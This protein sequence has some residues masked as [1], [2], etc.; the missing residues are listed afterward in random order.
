M[1]KLK[2]FSK[3]H[4]E[5]F[6]KIGIET[7]YLFGSQVQGKTHQL[8][9]FDF[10]VIFKKPE[11]YRDNTMEPYLKLYDILTDVLPKNYLKRRLKLKEH[12]LDIVFLQFAP[13]S[14]QFNAIK[15]SKVLYEKNQEKRLN[16]KENILK[17][18]CDFKYFY[19]LSYNYLLKRL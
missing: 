1:I 5:Q 3:K 17:K 8:S 6:E 9:D 18:Y 10:G 4:I 19:D 13:I 14:L 16:Y 2:K 15:N 12:E 11:K 7:I